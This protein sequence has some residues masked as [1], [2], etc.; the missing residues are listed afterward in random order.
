MPQII[1]GTSGDAHILS[2][3]WPLAS[4]H[5]HGKATTLFA[6]TDGVFSLTYTIEEVLNVCHQHNPEATEAAIAMFQIRHR[7]APLAPPEVKH[8]QA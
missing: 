5:V 4:L 1:H 3:T 6:Y 8:G 7:P 2:D